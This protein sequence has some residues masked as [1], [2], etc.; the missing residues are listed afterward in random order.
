M[1]KLFRLWRAR[2]FGFSIGEWDLMHPV[3]RHG[4][5][6]VRRLLSNGEYDYRP[7]TEIEMRDYLQADAW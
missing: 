1:K 6:Y 4:S 3:R 5:L 7:M 2:V